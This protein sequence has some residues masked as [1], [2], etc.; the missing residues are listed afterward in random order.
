MKYELRYCPYCQKNCAIVSGRCKSCGRP[1]KWPEPPAEVKK[2]RQKELEAKE[3]LRRRERI[4]GVV[5][6]FAAAALFVAFVVRIRAFVNSPQRAEYRK[7]HEHAMP[8]CYN[9]KRPATRKSEQ[10]YQGK[11]KVQ[12]VWLCQDCVARASYAIKGDTIDGAWSNS[13]PIDWWM[14]I[15]FG[16]VW[17]CFIAAVAN[18]SHVKVNSKT[19]PRRKA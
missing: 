6:C 17:L 14:W 18:L 8:Y 3:R 19:S 10:V 12:P 16:G 1:W 15:L 11:G 7:Q 13:P 4:R 9:C 2:Q 5:F